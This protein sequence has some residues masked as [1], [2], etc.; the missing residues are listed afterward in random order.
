MRQL[1]YF[2]GSQM[3]QRRRFSGYQP[4]VR[5]GA[6]RWLTIVAEKKAHILFAFQYSTLLAL[7]DLCGLGPTT[8]NSCKKKTFKKSAQNC[9]SGMTHQKPQ[10][11]LCT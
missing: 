4:D 2:T 9:V 7:N 8:R 11:S 5:H 10:K 3:A 1:N 6:G